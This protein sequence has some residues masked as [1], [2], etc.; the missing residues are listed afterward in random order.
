MSGAEEPAQPIQSVI[1]T[2]LNDFDEH[3]KKLLELLRRA[4]ERSRK[5][6]HFDEDDAW[7]TLR[8]EAFIYL[9]REVK[10]SQM[11]AAMPTG[12]RVKL[13]RQ[14]GDALSDARCKADEAMK[15]VRGYWFME[16]AVANGDPDFTD[17]RIEL[18]QDEFDTRIAYLK[19]LEEAAY[20]AAEVVRRKSGRPRGTTALPDDFILKLE[21][22]YRN[23][24][25]TSAGAGPG[26]FARFVGEFLT[27][28]GRTYPQQ[29]VIEAIKAAKR[30][31]A[32]PWEWGRDLF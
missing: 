18:Y 6:K 17:P 1:D 23:A 29:T 27:A 31:G 4:H 19:G 25:D 3:K 16:W 24:T 5:T 14:L 13:L 9:Q 20:K 12:D 15:T 10:V 21:S 32:H 11:Q 7:R 30:R 2:R 28:L 8:F 22:T 26:P